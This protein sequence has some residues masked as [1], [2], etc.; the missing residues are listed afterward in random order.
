MICPGRSRAPFPPQ[1]L[2][3]TIFTIWP[4]M[5]IAWI[6]GQ[7]ALFR[8]PTALP[9]KLPAASCRESSIL[10]VVLFILIAR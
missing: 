9:L 3:R 10:K 6:S 5:N 4:L 8:S 2:F 7:D 1:P